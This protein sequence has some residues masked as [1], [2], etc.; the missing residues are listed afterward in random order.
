MDR[1]KKLLQGSL[2]S[3]IKTILLIVIGFFMLPFLIHNLGDKT[4]GLW[5][6]VMTFIDYYILLRM[7]F[8]SAT[9]RHLARA[10]GVKDTEEMSKISSTA[11]FLYLIISFLMIILTIILIFIS[12]I[13]VKNSQNLKLFQKIILVLGIN[14]AI[15]PPFSVFGAILYAHMRYKIS[16]LLNILTLILKNVLIYIFISNNCGLFSISLIYL[17]C[18]VLYSSLLFIYVKINFNYIKIRIKLFRKK[19]FKTLFSYSLFTFIDQI[20]DKLRYKVDT[21]VITAFI[22]LTAITHYNVGYS[23]IMYYM[24][25]VTKLFTRFETYVSQ[26]EGRGNYKSIR[27]KFMFITKI[28]TFISV[29]F[30]FSMIY[31]GRPFI[32]RWMGIGYDDSYYILIILAVSTIFLLAQYPTTS[33]LYGISKNKFCAYTN[34]IEGIFNVII[35]IILVKYFGLIGIAIGTAIPMLIMK[36]IFQPIYITKILNLNFKYYYKNFILN[37][38]NSTS[39]LLVYFFITNWFIRSTYRSIFIIGF[40]QLVFFITISYQFYFKKKEKE[41]F[42]QLFKSLKIVK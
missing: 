41:K 4:Y 36:L 27:E 24:M 26:E 15:S 5:V 29:F 3:L 11:F 38:I 16:A 9:S 17:F 30:G 1:G 28:S 39:I 6:L 32:N 23:L 18:N 40:F 33:V 2:F 21:I 34:I 35:S 31:Y 10:V 14:T 22:G 37:F 12:G 7:G 19:T 8:S 25:I 13:I 42:I 20:A